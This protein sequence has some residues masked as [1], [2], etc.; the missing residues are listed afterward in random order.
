MQ[1]VHTTI[2]FSSAVRWRHHCA[3]QN[4]LIS[5]STDKPLHRC[6][7]SEASND[8]WQTLA[9]WMGSSCD[10]C[11]VHQFDLKQGCYWSYSPFL[12]V[13][14][15]SARHLWVVFTLS[16]SQISQVTMH[17]HQRS[18]FLYLFVKTVKQKRILIQSKAQC[19]GVFLQTTKRFRNCDWKSAH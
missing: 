14:L 5:S 10:E 4:M 16:W 15:G 11:V 3:A 6:R 2:R 9:K 8:P 7:K 13:L 18:I 17:K 19:F 1:T 12:F